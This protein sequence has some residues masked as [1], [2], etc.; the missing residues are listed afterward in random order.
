MVDRNPARCSL[1]LVDETDSVL[2]RYPMVRLPIREE[3]VVRKSIEYFDDPEPCFLHRSAV[4]KRL[5]VEI[6]DVFLESP[7]DGTSSI[8][9]A[10]LPSH[11]R[12]SLE[13]PDKA[14]IRRA[15][16]ERDT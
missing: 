14:R 2:G 7:S 8:E 15:R 16:M 9:W 3:V 10:I 13:L 6:L 11:L 1:V 4:L 5:L 12:D